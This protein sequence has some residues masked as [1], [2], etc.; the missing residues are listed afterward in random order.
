MRDGKILD[1]STT[2]FKEQTSPT[3]HLDCGGLIVAPGFLELQINGGYGIDFSEAAKDVNGELAAGIK[4]VGQKLLSHG[5]TAF[6]PTIISSDPA[7]Y[8]RLLPQVTVQPPRVDCA[9]VLGAHLEGPFISAG[10]CGM[11]PTMTLHELASSVDEAAIRDQLEKVYGAAFFDPGRVALV[12]LAPEQPGSSMAIRLLTRL[13]IGVSLG[14][15]EATLEQG[16]V[17]VAAGACLLTHLFSAMANFH[18]RD[19]GLVGLLTALPPAKVPHYGLIVDG[20]HTSPAAVRIAQRAHPA[21]LV[22]TSDANPALGLPDGVYRMGQRDIEVRGNASYVVGT[23]TLSGSV[24]PLDACLRQLVRDTGCNVAAALQ[25]VTEHPAQV[26][27]I[28]AQRGSLRAGAAA[29]LV[30][31]DEG[32]FVQAVMVAGQL[33]HCADPLRRRDFLARRIV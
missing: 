3:W 27:G 4:H 5:I 1:P 29:D 26:L 19:P 7:T 33:A 30:L 10:K 20:V 24:A 8:R 6:C 31:L 13:G 18:H 15:S 21:G 25:A 2:F 12:T 22:L 32:L 23:S 9:G 28:S 16:V 14:H 11:H 17:A